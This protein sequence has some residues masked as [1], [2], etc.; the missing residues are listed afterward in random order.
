M[1]LADRPK[2]SCNLAKW[3]SWQVISMLENG[4]EYGGLWDQK[5]PTLL[6]LDGGAA[7]MCGAG[8][9][10]GQSF[11]DAVSYTLH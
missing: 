8:L 9:K 2:G 11:L 4:F 3:K 5:V 6:I 1:D 7:N 10:N